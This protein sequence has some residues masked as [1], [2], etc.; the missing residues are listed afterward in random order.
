MIGD[1]LYRS[2]SG[3]KQAVCCSRCGGWVYVFALDT[4]DDWHALLEAVMTGEPP[5]A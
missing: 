3:E 1:G 2:I 5:R 4:H